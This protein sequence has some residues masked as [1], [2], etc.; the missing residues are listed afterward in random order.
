MLHQAVQ[1][2]V[3]D[4]VRAVVNAIRGIPGPCRPSL[5]A[6]DEHGNTALH[7]AAKRSRIAIIQELVY[8]NATISN[9]DGDFPLHVAARSLSGINMEELFRVLARHNKDMDINDWNWRT[10]DTAL[11]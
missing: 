8:L 2:E 10:G 1:S 9:D 5:E 4:V 3:P 7:L 11:H 6:A